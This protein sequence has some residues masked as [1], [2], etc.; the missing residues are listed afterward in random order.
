MS[1]DLTTSLLVAARYHRHVHSSGDQLLGLREIERHSSK[2]APALAGGLPALR[3][4][5][6]HRGRRAVLQLQRRQQVRHQVAR[7]Q[8]SLDRPLRQRL[9]RCEEGVGPVL[10]L[11]RRLAPRGRDL[12]ELRVR[13]VG[14]ARRHTRGGRHL[15]LRS[16]RVRALL[17]FRRGVVEAS[18]FG[19]P[20]KPAR[21]ARGARSAPEGR[22]EAPRSGAGCRAAAQSA[23]AGG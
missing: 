17:G 2:A 8:H 13:Q 5:R 16:L 6:A 14:E 11:G 22:R 1:S 12:H 15:C 7:E 19:V 3:P 4:P 10:D 9:V 18:I 20:K 23:A 21:A